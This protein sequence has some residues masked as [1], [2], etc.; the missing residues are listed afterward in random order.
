MISIEA[1]D[2]LNAT[3]APLSPVERITLLYEFFAQD[4][5]LVT[6]SFGTKSALLLYWLSNIKSSQEIYFLDT[7]YHFEETLEYKDRLANAFGLKVIPIYPERTAHQETMEQALWTKNTSKCCYVNKVLP[8]ELVKLNYEVWVSGLMAY[9]TPYRRDLK[10]FEIKDNILKFYPLIDL[11]QA[12]FDEN[13]QTAD[14]PSHP[15]EVLGYKSIGCLHCT[16]RGE[17]RDGRWNDSSKTECGLH[18][19]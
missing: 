14:L 12:D 4:S 9:Q 17:G 13:Y 5:I 7:G 18:F 8:L 2:N 15:L 6:S 11:S 3:F 1:L 16:Q 10:V 19:G